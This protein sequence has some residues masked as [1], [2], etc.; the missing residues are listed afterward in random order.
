[1][2]IM[3]DAGHGYNTPGKRSP[4]GMREYEF[5][6][7]VASETK[8]ILET[9]KDVTVYFSHSDTKDV[10]LQE[11]TDKANR[12]AVDCFV[13]IHANAFGTGWND[14]S[15]IETYVY[16]S[17]PKVATELASKVQKNLV[18]ATGL[19]DRGVKTANFHVL[20]AT[21]MT[22]I[23][24]ECGFMTNKADLKLLRSNVYRKT[25]AEAIVKGLREQFG[26]NLKASAAPV[27]SQTAA[28]YKV[29]AGPFQEKA[30][31]DKL[32]TKLKEEGFPVSI[33]S[34]R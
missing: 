9:Y 4:D 12:L 25:C 1:M 14:V 24:V 31:A 6:R 34:E 7:V 15:G 3:L 22:A 20:R 32:L 11:R 13:S 10:S 28:Q 16:T 19:R 5:N 8:A 33:V 26:L 27:P 17:K 23:L 30:T 21:K 18:V 2:K 29:V